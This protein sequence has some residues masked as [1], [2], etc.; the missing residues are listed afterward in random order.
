MLK[1]ERYSE[2]GRGMMTTKE[3][4]KKKGRET[5]KERNRNKTGGQERQGAC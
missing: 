5:K 4:K 3:R 2:S 1:D